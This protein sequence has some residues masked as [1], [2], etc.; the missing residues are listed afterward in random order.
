MFFEKKQNNFVLF[1]IDR[2][3]KKLNWHRGGKRPRQP[4]WPSVRNG[5]ITWALNN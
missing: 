2:M 5:D 3:E 4:D 1:G